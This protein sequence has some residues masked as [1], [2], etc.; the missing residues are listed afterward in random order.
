MAIVDYGNYIQA[1]RYRKLLTQNKTAEKLKKHSSTQSRVE[2]GKQLPMKKNAADDEF[3]FFPLD[4]Q[5]MDVLAKR[6]DVIYALD[7]NEIIKASVLLNEMKCLPNMDTPVNK[8]F[9]YSQEARLLEQQ[10]KPAPFIREM[11]IKGLALT[12]NKPDKTVPG[13]T[14]LLYEEPELFHTLARTHAQSGN[15]TEAIRVLKSLEDNFNMLPTWDK[16]KERRAVPVLLSLARC[17]WQA[18]LYNE[19]EATCR[20]GIDLSA[21]RRRGLHIPDFLYIQAQLQQA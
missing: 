10:G 12:F 6:Q 17:Q 18:G 4:N 21:T 5:P 14:A 16:D 1:L 15:L 20:R 7:K 3:V 13:T 8:Q 9:L 19:A 2:A 11:V